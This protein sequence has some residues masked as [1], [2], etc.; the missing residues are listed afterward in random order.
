MDQQ[1]YLNSF[2]VSA[3][4]NKNACTYNVRHYSRLQV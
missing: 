3:A 2:L 1:L 4:V